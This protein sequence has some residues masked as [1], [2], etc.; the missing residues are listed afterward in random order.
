MATTKV[1]ATK[2]PAKS[3]RQ[4]VE[5]EEPARRGRV[6]PIDELTERQRSQL[7]T[8][9][10]RLREQ[11]TPWDGPEGICVIED[12]ITSATV[13][14]KLLRAYGGDGLIRERVLD[15]GSSAK[16]KPAA[17]KSASKKPAAKKKTVLVRGTKRR[18]NP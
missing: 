4:V 11:G 10:T 1:K 12:M 7:A 6:S 9:V 2:R 3:A 18:S 15:N 17:K 13:G 16:R 5:E 8:R 14:R